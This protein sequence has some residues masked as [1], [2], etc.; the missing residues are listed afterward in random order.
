[1]FS[2]CWRQRQILKEDY[3]TSLFDSVRVRACD[4]QHPLLIRFYQVLQTV[5]SDYFCDKVLTVNREGDV[6]VYYTT[7]FDACADML[8]MIPDSSV[9][10]YTY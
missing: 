8:N 10:S 4:F 1:M 7:E 5:I 6:K 9:Q 3:Y 2:L